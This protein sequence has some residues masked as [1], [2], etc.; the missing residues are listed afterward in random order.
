MPA[1]NVIAN[2]SPLD[3]LGM[4]LKVIR[5]R[6]GD[7]QSPSFPWTWDAD[8]SKTHVF[9]EAGSGEEVTTKDA[10]PAIY[11]DRGPIVFPKVA[12]GD[13][14]GMNYK[15]GKKAYY[16]T[17]TGQINVDC[18]S[19]NRGESA[20]LGEIAQAFI[21]MTSDLI[22]SQYFFR[23]ITPVTLGGTEV[24]EKDDRLFNTR[25]TSRISYDVKWGLTHNA[26]KIAEII[27]GV[28]TKDQP[29]FAEIASNSL[30]RV[31]PDV[32]DL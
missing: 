22:I 12:I 11:V 31:I 15:T 27:T 32:G 5:T 4:F 19:K 6:F 9:I 21:L 2:K 28:G 30:N 16:T 24:W 20:I 10:R 18:V 7:L 17:A 29:N 1:T 26:P 13:F 3:I 14:A 8:I 25:V 23:D